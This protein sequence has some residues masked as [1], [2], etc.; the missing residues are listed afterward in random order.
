MNQNDVQ[1]TSES[2]N[3]P[4]GSPRWVPTSA[5][6][7]KFDWI[8]LTSSEWLKVDFKVLYDDKLEFDSDEL[9]L[10]ELDWE[11]V[12]QVRGHKLNS[13]RFEDN[14]T[15]A[16]VVK[17]IDDKVFVAD[18]GNRRVMQYDTHGF[19]EGEF[20]GK[21]NSDDAHGFVI[22][23]AFFDVAVYQDELWVAN[24]GMHALENYTDD[25][26]LRGFWDKS[27][28]KIEGFSG[29]CNPSHFALLADGGFVT[30]EKGLPRVKIHN[31]DGSFRCVVAAPDQFDDDVVGLDLAVT[32]DGKI[33]VLDPARNQVRIFEEI[34]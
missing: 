6:P 21:R 2:M 8:Q 28:M 9:G 31:A 13:V 16:G 14:I 30:A 24:T 25:G 5:F 10:L 26:I 22:P 19:L 32:S 18:A 33:M 1:N 4:Y 7:E 29:C 3:T 17:I 20:E 12:K 23:S 15:V 11:D 27:T 34:Q